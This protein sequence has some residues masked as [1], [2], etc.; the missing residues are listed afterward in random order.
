MPED[1]AAALA[2]L[3]RLGQL[4]EEHRG[5]LLVVLRRRIDPSLTRRL[6]AE[7]ILGDAFLRAR[8]RWATFKAGTMSAYAWLYR[9]ALDCLIEAWRRETRDRRDLRDDLPWPDASSVQLGLGLINPATSPTQAAARAEECQRVRTVLQL[10]PEKDREIL[11]MRHEDELTHAEVGEV[12][13]ITENAAT[14]RYVRALRRLK[15]LWQQAHPGRET[16]P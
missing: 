14:V 4:F 6:D 2:D 15:T 5:R 7:D 9:L 13:G 8:Q 12:L 11:R 10:L 3:A 1:S 16:P